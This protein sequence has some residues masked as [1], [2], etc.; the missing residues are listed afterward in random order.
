MQSSDIVTCRF[1]K[2]APAGSY[3]KGLGARVVP[4]KVIR[5]TRARA[6]AARGIVE[7]IRKARAD[8]P[9]SDEE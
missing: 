1:K 9:A 4:G 7:N 2:S 6:E 5:T 3:H 8:A